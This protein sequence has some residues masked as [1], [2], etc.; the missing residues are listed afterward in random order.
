M[1][2]GSTEACNKEMH[3]LIKYVL[4]TKDTVLELWPTGV[5][6]EPKSMTV[7][8]DSNYVHK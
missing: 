3:C 2:D 4:D 8:T 7:F 1:P 5:M 6:G